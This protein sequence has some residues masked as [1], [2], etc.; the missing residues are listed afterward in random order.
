MQVEYKKFPQAIL[1]T[2]YL[3]TECTS[4]EDRFPPQLLS[5]GSKTFTY[6]PDTHCGITG[7]ALTV[8][9]KDNFTYKNSI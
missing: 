2:D 5:F 7:A 4:E 9:I 3:K 1:L 6:Y 8:V